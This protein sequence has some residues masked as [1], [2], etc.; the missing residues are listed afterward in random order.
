MVKYRKILDTNFPSNC[1]QMLA[2]LK[3]YGSDELVNSP[4]FGLHGSTT[5]PF[6]NFL[7]T[8]F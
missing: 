4:K 2:L 8:L 7:L 5:F 3:P 6:H 1:L